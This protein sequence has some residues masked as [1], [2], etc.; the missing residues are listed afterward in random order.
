MDASAELRDGALLLMRQHARDKGIRHTIPMVHHT[1]FEVIHQ[2]ALR[3][4]PNRINF[5]LMA[6][7]DGVDFDEEVKFQLQRVVDAAG[8]VPRLKP[9]HPTDPN[10]ELVDGLDTPP[11]SAGASH[12]S[13]SSADPITLKARKALRNFYKADY[14]V[15]ELLARYGC[16]GAESCLKAAEAI[17]KEGRG[18]NDEAHAKAGS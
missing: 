7:V 15:I 5:Y 4:A 10:K 13:R 18:D 16:G 3:G 9:N 17:A 14:A 6:Q 11:W 2:M 12:S 1:P 8:L